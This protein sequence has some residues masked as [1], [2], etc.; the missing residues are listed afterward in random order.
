MVKYIFFSLSL[1]VLSCKST[2]CINDHRL[3][4]KELVNLDLSFL[5]EKSITKND[6]DLI[7]SG[8]KLKNLDIEY[9][10]S[11]SVSYDD[12]QSIPMISTYERGGEETWDEYKSYAL[13]DGQLYYLGKYESDGIGL[14]FILTESPSLYHDKKNKALYMITEGTSEKW[15]TSLAL[16]LFSVDSQMITTTK[17]KDETFIYNDFSYKDNTCGKYKVERSGAIKLLE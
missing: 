2:L 15:C 17:R 9:L 4:V 10:K 1:F 8:E 12:F 5:E 16:S 14:Y 6:F 7:V 11:T 13:K 3:I